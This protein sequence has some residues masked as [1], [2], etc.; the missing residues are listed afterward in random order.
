MK[1]ILIPTDFSDNAWDALIYAIRLY[2][3]IPCYFYILNTYEISSSTV[4]VAVHS[5]ATK[6]LYTILREDSEKGLSKIEA[7]LNEYLL[8]DKHEYK[9][10]SKQ[11]NLVSIAKELVHTKNIDL[12][13]M[14]TTGASGLKEVLMGSTA[15]SVIKNIAACPILAVPKDYEFKEPE[16]VTFASDLKRLFG[17]T[18]L[19]ALMELLLIHNLELQILHVKKEKELSETQNENIANIKQHLGTHNISFRE[20]DF[21]KSISNTINEYVKNNEVNIICLAKYEHT[22]L[23]RMLHEPVIKKVGF[24]SKVPLLVISV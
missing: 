3:D 1:K 6:K 2:N 18:E 21:D 8:N 13:V 20:I 14:G 17:G 12:I 10:I 23:E 4:N 15:M 19:N 24:H 7:Y 5:G 16:L 11:G 22:F 9:I